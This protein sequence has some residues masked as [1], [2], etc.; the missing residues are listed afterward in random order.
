MESK[1]KRN[2]EMN[3][4][5]PS[6]EGA[7]KLSQLEFQVRHRAFC[8]SKAPGHEELQLW[9]QKSL[10]CFQFSLLYVLFIVVWIL[11]FPYICCLNL[12]H[13]T[14]KKQKQKLSKVRMFKI[15]Q[16]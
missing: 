12:T 6:L 1:R 9:L 10:A 7:E 13:L 2:P 3:W 14:L 16:V 4:V 11:V 8:L 5:D 15:T